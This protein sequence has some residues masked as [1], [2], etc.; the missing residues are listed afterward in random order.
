M[1]REETRPIL[2]QDQ[3]ILVQA[4]KS[5]GHPYRWWTATVE[6]TSGNGIVTLI[7]AGQTIEMPGGNSETEFAM[8]AYYWFDKPYN[9]VEVYNPDGSLE[10]IY[11]HISSPP[12]IRNSRLRYT[13]WEL[14]VILYPGQ[15]PLILDE[16]EFEQAAQLYG[17]TPHFRETCYDAVREAVKIASE[18]SPRG[19]LPRA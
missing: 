9:L 13:D 12:V 19:Y 6:S 18:W 4:Y 5:D 14:D 8:R 15:N 3:Q 11:I 2:K 17:Y 16:D 7:P 1:P 10:E